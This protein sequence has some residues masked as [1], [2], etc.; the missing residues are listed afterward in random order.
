M[1]G[2]RGDACR[3]Y[4]SVVDEGC[5]AC[6]LRDGLCFPPRVPLGFFPVSLPGSELHRA[7]GAHAHR[8]S[9]TPWDAQPAP[10]ASWQDTP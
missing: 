1:V 4:P 3:C 5:A 7:P 8:A 6:L 10:P 9:A 2:T